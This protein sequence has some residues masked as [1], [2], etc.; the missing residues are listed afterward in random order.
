[1]GATARLAVQVALPPPFT[2]TQVHEP[3]AP[4]AGKA[5]D[6][7]LAVPAAQNVPENEASAARYERAA[8]PH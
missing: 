1:M 5:G 6:A 8:V 3:V 7:G 2:P 4:C